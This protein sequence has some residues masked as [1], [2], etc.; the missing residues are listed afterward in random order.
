MKRFLL[1]SLGLAWSAVALAQRNPAALAARNWRET[2]ERAILTEFM[3]LLAMLNLAR[4]EAAVRKNANAIVSMLEK[5]GVKARWL[6]QAGVPPVVFGE[7]NTPGATR[8]LMFYA[9]YDGQ[10]L[11]PKEW[12][13]PPWQPV[14][15]D[16]PLNEDGRVVSVPASGKIDPEWRIY[17]RSASDDKAP[18]IA[19]STALDALN[20][21][22]IP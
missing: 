5:R 16:R 6:E 17:A 8:T 14:L 9:H 11:D 21:A 13:T 15:R 10:P 3:D 7:I 12:A 18:T 20:A 1:V 22:P 19:L 2:H 4:D